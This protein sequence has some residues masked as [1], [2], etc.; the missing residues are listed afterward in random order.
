MKVQYKGHESMFR[1]RGLAT[2]KENVFSKNI[3][4]Q[5]DEKDIAAMVGGNF[6]IKGKVEKPKEPEVEKPKEPKKSVS[7]HKK[8]V[9]RV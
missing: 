5:V 1:F 6:E 3:D 4:T 9:V 2:G 7:F 8:P